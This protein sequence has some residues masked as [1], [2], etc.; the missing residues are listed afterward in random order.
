MKG[1][2]YRRRR[3]S[4][5]DSIRIR[6]A[7][8]LPALAL[9]AGEQVADMLVEKFGGGLLAAPAAFSSLIDDN[10]RGPNPGGWWGSLVRHDH[11]HG[12]GAG[13]LLVR[14]RQAC[15][16]RIGHPR[17]GNGSLSHVFGKQGVHIDADTV[18]EV[19]ADGPYFIEPGDE[20][21]AV[22]GR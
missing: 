11:Q 4:R 20:E 21:V 3:R 18:A 1:G 10:F 13:G 2:R 14:F 5:L 22:A 7:S 15:V 17:R 19:M 16:R 6:Y 12:G 9:S 8:Q